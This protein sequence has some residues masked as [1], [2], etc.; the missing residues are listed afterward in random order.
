MESGTSRLEAFSDGVIAIIITIM[1]LELRA[2]AT[3]DL[4]GLLQL[5]PVFL[6][7]VLSFTI[8]AIYWINHHQILGLARRVDARVLWTN[9]NLLFWMS[10]MPL[11]TAWL[12]ESG[13]APL[14]TACYAGVATLCGGSFFLLRDAIGRQ[15]AEDPAFQALNRQ[16]ARKNFV[17]LAIYI[18]ATA[19]ALVAPA[20]S[21]VLCALPAL[22]YFL[23][24]RESWEGPDR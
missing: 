12:G 23:P 21:L 2:P 15:R 20:A 7:Y 8:A 1:V 14:P 19:C 5:A 24:T 13:A 16:M 17:A 3:A 22:M 10:L 18:S 6:S 4:H 11:T 9:I